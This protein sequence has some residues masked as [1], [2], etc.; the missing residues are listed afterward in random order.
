MLVGD[1]PVGLLILITLFKADCYEHHCTA[2]PCV[3]SLL[4]WS[5][6]LVVCSLVLAKGA[7]HQLPYFVTGIQL[8]MGGIV[9]LA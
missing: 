3:W 5:C 7:D 4:A 2:E 8:G 9:G 1:S 6:I